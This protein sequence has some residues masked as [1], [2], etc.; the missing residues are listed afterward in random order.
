MTVIKKNNLLKLE[1]KLKSGCQY[2][3]LSYV[4]ANQSSRLPLDSKAV[5]VSQ[6]KE[7]LVLHLKYYFSIYR[8]FHPDINFNSSIATVFNDSISFVLEDFDQFINKNWVDSNLSSN[9]SLSFPPEL[10][11]DK[12]SFFIFT[13]SLENQLSVDCLVIDRFNQLHKQDIGNIKKMCNQDWSQLYKEVCIH[14]TLDG[15]Q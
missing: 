5:S 8:E 10:R 3:M 6:L 4:K 15:I 12:D 13:P 11:T 1:S 14:Y 9:M 2:L 7:M